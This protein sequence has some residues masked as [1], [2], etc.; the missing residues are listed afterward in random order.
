MCGMDAWG[1]WWGG[2]GECGCVVGGNDVDALDGCACGVGLAVSYGWGSVDEVVWMIRSM[3]VDVD[4]IV[5]RI[6]WLMEWM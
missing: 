5:L 6:M 2:L 1:G 3:N 4:V